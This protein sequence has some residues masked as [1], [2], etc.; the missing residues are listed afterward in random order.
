MALVLLLASC[1]QDPGPGDESSSPP[2][3]QQA[4]EMYAA[5]PAILQDRGLPLCL[6]DAQGFR[7]APPGEPTAPAP[8]FR[9]LDG[10]VYELGS[11]E[12]AL[13]RRGEL[14]VYRYADSQQRDEAA[15][16]SSRRNARPDVMWTYGDRFLVEEWIFGDGDSNPGFPELANTIH[17][18]ISELPEARHFDPASVSSD[19]PG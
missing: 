9:Y 19:H 15:V 10:R 11:C 1:G 5:V 16:T 14:R 3:D 2:L 6:P 8:H 12:L 4:S 18:T 13:D 17:N 7:A